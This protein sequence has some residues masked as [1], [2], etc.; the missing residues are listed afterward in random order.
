MLLDVKHQVFQILALGVID[1]YRVVGR[2]R[3]LVEYAHTSPRYRRSREE[4]RAEQLF[5][6]RLRAR[7]TRSRLQ[8]QYTNTRTFAGK[9]RFGSPHSAMDSAR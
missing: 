9:I 2:L 5:R 3:K 6:H 8:N 1:I 4:C 7:T